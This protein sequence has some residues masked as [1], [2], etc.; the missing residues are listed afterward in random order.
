MLK[1]IL[2]SDPK[3]PSSMPSHAI[4]QNDEQERTLRA[5]LSSQGL[6]GSEA[7]EIK[8]TEDFW[9]FRDYMNRR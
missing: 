4:I 7:R 2:I 6:I 5:K 1:S 3:M 8:P 9:R